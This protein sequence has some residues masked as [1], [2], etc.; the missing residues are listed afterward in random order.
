VLSSTGTGNRRN[1][2]LD[3]GEGEVE[4]EVGVEVEGGR[5]CAAQVEEWGI[6]GGWGGFGAV[7]AGLVPT[8][9]SRFLRPRVE[10]Q[11]PGAPERY[12]LFKKNGGPRLYH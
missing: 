9:F 5:G 11:L 3:E 6:N 10:D 8:S 7:C 1:G 2:C 12:E 4:D